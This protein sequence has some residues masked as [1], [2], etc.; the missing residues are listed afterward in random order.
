[1][2]SIREQIVG[3][4]QIGKERY[5]HGVIVDSDTREWGTP[6]NSWIDMAVEEF[7][8]AIIYVIADYIR[9]GRQSSRLLTELELDY[10]VNDDF[11]RAPD[12]VEYLLENHEPDDNK[13]IMHILRNYNKIE[14]PKHHMLVW[15]LL[16]M[17]LVSSQ[18]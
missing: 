4:L 10:K 16:N 6:K 18:F 9:Q 17:L 11:A 1:M 5:G 7:L 14:S 13:L 2:E 3:R 8:D 15:N 12:P